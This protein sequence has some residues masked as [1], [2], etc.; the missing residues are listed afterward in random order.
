MN[1]AQA[2]LALD[3]IED[4]LA[5]IESAARH[6]GT[7]RDEDLRHRHDDLKACVARSLGELEELLASRGRG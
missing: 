5:R 1:E 2:L 7:D 6:L 3:R 4:A